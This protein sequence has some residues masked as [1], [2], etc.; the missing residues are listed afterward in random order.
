MS[1]FRK[2]LGREILFFDGAMGTCLQASGLAAGECPENRNITDPEL[3]YNVH[4]EYLLAGADVI[5]ANTFGA[6]RI[7]L[8][9]KFSVTEVVKAGIGIAKKAVS[10]FGKKAY[11]ALDIGST[12]KLLKPYGS[13]EFEEAYNVFA[14][15][16]KAGAEA[17]ADLVS[18]E[19]MT[20]IYET[21]A[22]I[23]A[24]KENCDLPLTVTVSFDGSGKMLTGTDPEVA[25]T[26]ITSLGADCI[27]INCGLGPE[28]C[29][30][31]IK[32]IRECTDLPLTVSPN[33]GL[34]VLRNGKTV[35]ELSPE[36]FAVQMKKWWTWER[37][38][39]VDVVERPLRT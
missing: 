7:K 6:N 33:A 29:L 10:D 16:V 13:L 34:P 24:V 17:G 3:I 21:K 19:T 39:L 18:I 37:V 4:K 30:P 8:D 25:A 14:E 32:R 12:G 2:R 36:K 11:V 1:D 5:L 23:L 22:A 15:M 28:Q 38:S 20:D 35:Y 9:G 26:V 27:G 31:L